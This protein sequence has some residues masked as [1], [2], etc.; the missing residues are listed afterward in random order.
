MPKHP[1]LSQISPVV[2]FLVLLE[3]VVFAL[4]YT[5]G[6]YL[7]GWDSLHPEFNYPENLKRQIFAVWQEYRGLGLLDGMAHAANLPHTILTLLF[8]LFLPQNVVRYALTMFM[9]LFGGLGAYSLI[10]KLLGNYKFSA[11]AGSIFYMFNL[12]AIQMFYTPFEVFV[13]H[14]AFLPWLAFFLINY[15][16]NGIKKSL[17]YLAVFSFFALPQAFV[18]QVFIAYAILVGF[19]TLTTIFSKAENKLKHLVSALVAIIGIN[20]IWILP[21]SYSVKYNP[22]IIINSKINQMSSEDTYLRNQA[23]GDLFNVLTLQGAML[24]IVEFDKSGQSEFIMKDWREHVKTIWFKVFSLG[25]TTLALLGFI[26]SLIKRNVYTLPFTGS[27]LASLFFLGSDIWG[28]GYLNSLMRSA[29][30]ILGEALR[31]PF[32]KFS[33]LFAL[34]LSIFLSYFLSIISRF[35]LFQKLPIKAASSIILCSVLLFYSLPVFKGNFLFKDLRLK[36]PGEYFETM[37]F[38]KTQST[39]DR[40]ATFPQPN[41]WSWRYHNNGYRGSGFLWMG[42][43]Q[44]MLDRAFDPWS[45]DN[46]GYYWEVSYALYSKNLELLEKVLDKYNVS[47]ILVDKN[48]INHTSPKSLYFDEF[49]ELITKST[50]I[51]LSKTFGNIEVYEYKS[52]LSKNVSNI[53]N[54]PQVGPVYSL[55]Y[56]DSAYKDLGV[57]KTNNLPSTV[58]PFRSL[59]TNKRQQDL[60]F[61]I[62]EEKDK[63]IFSKDVGENFDDYYLAIPELGFDELTSLDPKDLGA[64]S[65]LSPEVS[66]DNG[67]VEVSIPKAL[68]YYSA[69]IDPAIDTGIQKSFACTKTYSDK[70]E[71][72]VFNQGDNSYINFSASDGNNC[73][74]SYWLPSLSYRWGYLFTFE[75]KHKSGKNLLFWLENVNTRKPDIETYLDTS[76]EFKTYYFVQPPMELYGYGYSLHFDNISIGRHE[77]ANQLG[78]V[79]VYPIPYRFLTELA[80]KLPGNQV[81]APVVNE[82]KVKHAFP[83]IYQVETKQPGTLILSESYHNGWL[84]Y[85]GSKR[86]N[87]HFRIN[88]WANGWDLEGDQTNK[89][90]TIIFWPQYLQFLG[91]AIGTLALCYTVYISYKK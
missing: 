28:I 18:P 15:L 76:K 14:F 89:K 35:N 32:T 25:L 55:A 64:K 29:I 11:L 10:R 27:L 44:P 45:R 4:N 17:P 33:I 53:S 68:N 47:W 88:N 34:S 23:R 73:N 26:Y 78:K 77:T 85:D 16:L 1:K 65:E 82:T 74:V 54:L 2:I 84:A 24:D 83:Y 46:E 81:I 52:N 58:Y 72:N 90:I 6:T 63:I 56:Q 22:E 62:R 59:Y 61:K 30:P 87:S 86:L 21:Y 31:F 8:D 19:I 13:F 7:I 36:V 9:H 41:F 66:F 12:A 40:I 42:I 43:S 80:F 57:Y 91:H 37:D 71:Y 67:I 69:E 79:S 5:P 50:A 49:S 3:L 38:F 70:A 48:T 60:E 20:S 39:E 51:S 75:A